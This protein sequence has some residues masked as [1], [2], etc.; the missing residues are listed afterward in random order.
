MVDS[1]YALQKNSIKIIYRV[2]WP[3][4]KFKSINHVKSFFL[5]Y[6][7]F[8]KLGF[9]NLYFKLFKTFVT[10]IDSKIV[11]DVNLI[12]CYEP[13][14]NIIIEM[15]TNYF[16]VQ[17][18]EW[19]I[20]EQKTGIKIARRAN[21]S[22]RIN[23][24]N[25]D[26]HFELCNSIV[27]P[28]TRSKESLPEKFQAKTKVIP[29]AEKSLL[30][31]KTIHH[32]K[33]NKLL[34]IGLVCPSKGYHYMIEGFNIL[35]EGVEIN[36]YGKINEEYKD[37]LINLANVQIKLNFHGN[38]KQEYLFKVIPMYDLLVVPSVSE[39]LPLSA[40]QALNSK[41]PV[42][43][44]KNSNLIDVLPE[45]CIYDTR[46]PSDFAKKYI[47][48]KNKKVYNLKTDNF[49]ESHIINQWKKI[50]ES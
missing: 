38:V 50:L 45:F 26:N 28:S 11:L 14:A 6:F 46:N 16:L 15:P 25:L 31:N 13:S 36:F 47:S 48:F 18:L 20:E 43:A 37:Y 29:F 42:F 22:S 23:Q 21:T 24:N 8:K 9:E 44:S 4:F 7:L 19:K 12:K 33:F 3:S 10:P 40:I 49:T 5:P 32:K 39:G 34:C 17:D 30:K 27:V 35:A 2:F 41:L 1:A